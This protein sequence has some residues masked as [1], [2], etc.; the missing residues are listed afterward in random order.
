MQR[1]LPGTNRETAIKPPNDRLTDPRQVPQSGTNNL[2]GFRVRWRRQVSRSCP[3]PG[4]NPRRSDVRCLFPNPRTRMVVGQSP[5]SRAAILSRTNSGA[6]STIRRESVPVGS[7][8][9]CQDEGGSRFATRSAHSIRQ[10]PSAPESSSRPSESK[11]SG[12][13]SR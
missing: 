5:L 7:S 13:S 12:S 2:R 9:I 8:A 11:A 4:T 3:R 6:R 10:R 1:S